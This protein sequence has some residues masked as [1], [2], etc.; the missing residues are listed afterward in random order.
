MSEITTEQKNEAIAIFDGWEFFKGD[1]NHKCNFCFAGDE[2]CT[3]AVDR[4]VKGGRVVFHYELKYHIDWNLLME[5]IEKIS[6]IK[7][8]NTDGTGCTDVQDVCYPR[9]FGMPTEDGKRVM[10]RFNGF[11]LHTADTLIEAAHAAM[12]EVAEWHLNKDK[13]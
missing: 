13:Q 5:V 9:T 12:Y 4:F 6:K 10:F 3:P 2:P 1:P 7:L 11:S 8:L